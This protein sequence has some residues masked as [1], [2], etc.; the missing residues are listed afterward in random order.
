MN[1]CLESNHSWNATNDTTKHSTHLFDLI[2][3][4]NSSLLLQRQSKILG[5][6]FIRSQVKLD[7]ILH[8]A[9]A[10]LNGDNLRMT[11]FLAKDDFLVRDIHGIL[12]RWRCFFREYKEIGSLDQYVTLLVLDPQ[13]MKTYGMTQ[14]D[15]AALERK[16]TKEVK[17]EFAS[18]TQRFVQKISTDSKQHMAP[19]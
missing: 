9:K 15:R 11:N 2:G 3:F 4:T 8:I 19:T 6:V 18:V 5:H 14:Y 16:T 7:L 10:G 17:Q 12:G 13:S 1:S